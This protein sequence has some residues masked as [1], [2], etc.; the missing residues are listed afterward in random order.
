MIFKDEFTNK[1]TH[2]LCV[3]FYLPFVSYAKIPV[4]ICLIAEQFPKQKLH[5]YVIPSSEFHLCHTSSTILNNVILFR[6]RGS[7]FASSTFLVVWFQLKFSSKFMLVKCWTHTL[8]TILFITKSA[9]R[10]CSVYFL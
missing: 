9:L 7:A 6:T 10:R 4:L 1:Y 5:L 2:I 8:F 3:V